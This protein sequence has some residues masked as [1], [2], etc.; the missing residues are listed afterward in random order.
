M[1]RKIAI[2]VTLIML[3]FSYSTPVFAKDDITGITLEK[4]MRAMV[5][6]GIIKGYGDGIYKPDVNVSRGEFATFISRALELPFVSETTFEDVEPSS[7][8]ADGINSASGVGI[9]TGYLDGTFKPDEN[10]T[11][12]QMAAMIYRALLYKGYEDLSMDLT[13]EDNGRI[14][15]SFKQA[16]SMNVYY[17]VINGYVTD[18]KSYFKPKEDARR[19]QAAAF[20]YRMLDLN[21]P[22]KPEEPSDPDTNTYFK[23]ASISN[24]EIVPINRNYDTFEEAESSITNPNNQVVLLG[25]KVVKMA[26]GIAVGSYPAS[27]ITIIYNESLKKQLTYVSNAFQ[28]E[29]KYLGADAEKIK[30]QVADTIG[31]VKHE[32]VTLI[33]TSLTTGESYYYVENGNLLHR[34]YYPI[35]KTYQYPYTVG[36]APGFMSAGQKYYSWNGHTYTNEGGKVVGESYPYF[37]RISVRTKTAYTAE[38]LNQY[39]L[40]KAP[41]GVL[42]GLGK[43]FKDAEEQYGVNALLMLSHAMLE[44]GNGESEIA[45]DKKNLFGINAT[46]TNPYENA[47]TFDTYADSINYYAK[48]VMLKKYV[49]PFGPYGKGGVFGN[50]SVGMNINYA[51][52]INWGQKVGGGFYIMDKELGGK[53]MLN[54]TYRIGEA[55]DHEIERDGLNVRSQPSTSSDIQFQIFKV[56]YPLTIIGEVQKPDGLWYKVISDSKEHKEAYIH[57]AYVKELNVAK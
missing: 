21:P 9:V 23:V 49:D 4:E 14:N 15:N 56:G 42:V 54:K 55:T 47:L 18:G 45:R 13:F 32:N 36:K 48:E 33:P 51:S 37:N 50:K 30:V 25:D 27:G 8:L 34:I 19:D 1:K 16:V 22:E 3:A 31:Y 26:S 53:D 35:T 12:E 29:M 24:G 52:D 44:T 10:V 28:S 43:D 17:K 20:I 40:K 46:D 2:I 6:K 39:I 7:S 38:E 41:N 11:R 5:D 57:G